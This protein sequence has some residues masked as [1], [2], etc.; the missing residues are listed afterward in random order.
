M[1]LFWKEYFLFYNS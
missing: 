1:L